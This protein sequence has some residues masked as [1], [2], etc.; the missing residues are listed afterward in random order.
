MLILFYK[1]FGWFLVLYMHWYLQFFSS[2][3]ILAAEYIKNA[4]KKKKTLLI[5]FPE[6][7]SVTL[8]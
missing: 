2:S 6:Q 4:K 5:F 3:K 8:L 1:S 7:T